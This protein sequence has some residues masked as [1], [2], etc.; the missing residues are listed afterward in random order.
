MSLGPG[1]QLQLRPRRLSIQNF[2]HDFNILLVK[3]FLFLETFI[4]EKKKIFFCAVKDLVKDL[5]WSSEALC[6]R[7]SSNHAG[8]MLAICG[9]P[10]SSP[11][12]KGLNCPEAALRLPNCS[13]KALPAVT[14]H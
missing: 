9:T 7:R 2:L 3:Y 10:S 13:G 11:S 14:V 4:P 12:P 6:S 8:D 1:H 5:P